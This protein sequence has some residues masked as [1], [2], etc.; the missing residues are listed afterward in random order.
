M[1]ATPHMTVDPD[2]LLMPGDVK[3]FTAVVGYILPEAGMM[4]HAQVF[5]YAVDARKAATRAEENLTGYLG[6]V[7][8]DMEDAQVWAM[9]V[10][11]G[12]IGPS[13]DANNPDQNP[14][15]GGEMEEIHTPDEKS[16]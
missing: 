1:N 3:P 6:S 8:H 13:Y 14:D 2:I 9:V 4:N 7:G 5:I 15:Q 12:H 10:F 16:H 11:D